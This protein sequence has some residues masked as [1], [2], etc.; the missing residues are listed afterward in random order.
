[1]NFKAKKPNIFE[2]VVFLIGIL[3]LIV[4]YY[5]INKVLNAQGYKLTWDFL[6]VLFL[7]LLMVIFIMLFAIFFVSSFLLAI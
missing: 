2:Q 6:Q 5:L 3:V 4:G 1:M 7:W